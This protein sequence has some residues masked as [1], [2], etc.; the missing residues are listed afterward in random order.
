M[1][2]LSFWNITERLLLP[3]AFRQNYAESHFLFKLPFSLLFRRH[4]GI[5][6]DAP[7]LVVPGQKIPL[8]LVVRNAHRFP[9]YMEEIRLEWHA[10][11]VPSQTR[12]IKLKQQINQPFA[13][14]ELNTDLPEEPGKWSINAAVVWTSLDGKKTHKQNITF[15]WNLPGLPLQPLQIHRLKHDLPALTGWVS[16]ETHCHSWHS[17]DPVEFGAPPQVLHQAARALGMGWFFITDHSYDFAWDQTRYMEATDAEA[18]WQTF[19]EELKEL[20]ANPLALSGEEVSVGNSQGRNVHMLALGTQKYIPGQGDGGRRWFNNSPDLSVEEAIEA[21]G[22]QVACFAAHPRVP[23]GKAESLVFRRGA[24]SATDMHPGI[25]GLQFWNGHT[26]A[27]FIE[28]RKFWVRQLLEGKKLLPLGGNDAHG[29]LNHTTGVALP[30]FKLKE[31]RNHILGRVRTWIAPAANTREAILETLREGGS[32]KGRLYISDGP[33]LVL[34]RQN[35][36]T[37]CLEGLSSPDFGQIAHIVISFGHPD[38]THERHV[39]FH[40]ES[41]QFNTET[42]PMTGEKYCRAE[43]TTTKGRRAL[44]APVWLNQGVANS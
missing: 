34:K 9:V 30:L 42:T 20:P 37:M 36:S 29:D 16:G 33:A 18:R 12:K 25:R 2:L 15:N 10:P 4:P 31:S 26:D 39:E 22:E 38:G 3:K 1:K 13:F 17:V 32:E 11:G 43:C 14:I 28:G 5:F 44:T 24:W 21:A 7:H 27:G 6:L 40:P 23:L 8:W 19:Q 41:L 35:Q